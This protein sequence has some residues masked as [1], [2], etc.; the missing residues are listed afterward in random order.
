MVLLTACGSSKGEDA[1]P[2]ASASVQ[3]SQPAG[4]KDGVTITKEEYGKIESG[5]TYKE[6]I[7]IVGGE[8][9][10]LSEAGKKGDKNYASVVMYK[11]KG[12]V[13][14]SA[15]F[16]FLNDELQTKSQLGLE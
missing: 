16:V 14:A 5:M 3:A 6:I 9:D 10:V 15:S 4:D 2:S 1:K 8:G 13:G 7:E 12:G 11:G